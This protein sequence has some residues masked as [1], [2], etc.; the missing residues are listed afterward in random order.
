[1]EEGSLDIAVQSEFS[2]GLLL[3]SNSQV[4]DPCT[5][6]AADSFWPAFLFVPHSI[7]RML[8]SSQFQSISEDHRVLHLDPPILAVFA[9]PLGSV[10]QKNLPLRAIQKVL[11][12]GDNLK[13]HDKGHS[14]VLRLG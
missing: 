1:M 10:D 11:T 8:S 7:V 14:L 3:A 5:L 2:S 4:L 6:V 12:F 9:L 13:G